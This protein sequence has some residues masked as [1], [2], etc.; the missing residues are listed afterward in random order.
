M[1]SDSKAGVYKCLRELRGHALAAGRRATT[2]GDF[3]AAVDAY[4]MEEQ[5]ADQLAQDAEPHDSRGSHVDLNGVPVLAVD[6]FNSE[7]QPVLYAQPPTGRPFS[8]DQRR[9]SPKDITFPP[10][11]DRRQPQSNT[12]YLWSAADHSPCRNWVMG[13]DGCSGHHHPPPSNP[14]PNLSVPS[15]PSTSTP[16]PISMHRLHLPLRYLYQRPH[17]P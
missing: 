14:S 5:L 1:C 15:P 9:D 10:F 6:N 11:T 8:R 3:T 12:A 13:K 17:R 4:L 2:P 7:T 16:P